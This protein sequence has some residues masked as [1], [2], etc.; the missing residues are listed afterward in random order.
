[1]LDHGALKKVPSLCCLMYSCEPKHIYNIQLVPNESTWT[2]FFFFLIKQVLY[3]YSE[4]IK[5][6]NPHI[7]VHSP[8]LETVPLHEPSDFCN[9]VMS[10][11]YSHYPRPRPQHSC[12]RKNSSYANVETGF[13]VACSDVRELTNRSSRH[14]GGL[15]ETVHYCRAKRGAA[16]MASK[17]VNNVF[18]FF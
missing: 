4:S 16:A 10:Q 12:G 5:M 7:N 3:N 6:I 2:C 1:M 18:F 17:R 11:L 9:V 14:W 15:K 13:G 8:Y